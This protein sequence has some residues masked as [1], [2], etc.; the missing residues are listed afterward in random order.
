MRLSAGEPIE[1]RSSSFY[2][3]RNRRNKKILINVF[4]STSG[5][6]TLTKFVLAVSNTHV[7]VDVLMF[8][9]YSIYIIIERPDNDKLR[10]AS[11]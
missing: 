1:C 6:T 8:L 10:H 2:L 11:F 3:R 4:I 9:V 7:D 5:S